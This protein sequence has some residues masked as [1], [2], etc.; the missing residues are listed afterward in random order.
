LQR[1]AR[2]AGLFSFLPPARASL[3]AKAKKLILEI[4]RFAA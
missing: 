3:I 4:A 1:P 2:K